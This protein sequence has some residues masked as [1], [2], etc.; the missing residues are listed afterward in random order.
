MSLLPLLLSLTLC[1]VFSCLVFV[2]RG[3]AR[4][5]GRDAVRVPGA[6]GPAGAGNALR[7]D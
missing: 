6:E 1:L 4:R 3:Q 5:P 2:L 7:A